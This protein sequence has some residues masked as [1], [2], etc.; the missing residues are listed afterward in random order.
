MQKQ[1]FHMTTKYVPKIITLSK[2]II[3]RI[4]SAV[5]EMKILG[6]LPTWRGGFL[7]PPNGIYLPS[8]IR[9]VGNESLALFRRA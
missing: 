6:L 1:K 2:M 7:C 9:F 4:L 3:D 8:I 5:R